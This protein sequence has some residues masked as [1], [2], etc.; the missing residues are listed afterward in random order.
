MKQKK[1]IRMTFKLYS[2]RR[3]SKFPPVKSGDSIECYDCGKDHFLKSAVCIQTEKKDTMF[4]VYYC[5]RQW[6]IGAAFGRLLI[7][8]RPDLEIKS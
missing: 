1:K 3:L 4:L 8:R 6:R 5:N 2:G 7:N